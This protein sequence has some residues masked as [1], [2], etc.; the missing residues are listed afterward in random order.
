MNLKQTDWD[1]YYSKPYQTA[2]FTR[3]FTRRVLVDLMRKY[4]PMQSSLTIAEWGGGNSAFFE[5]IYAAIKPAEYH[6]LDNNQLGLDKFSERIGQRAGVAL[7]Q[8]DVLNPPCNLQADIVYSVG[9]IEHF[10]PQQ[11]ARAIQAHF[12]MVKPGGLVLITFPTPTFLYRAT[13]RVA[14]GLGQWIF[15]DERPLGFDEVLSSI[16][17]TGKVVHQ[18]I[19]WPLFLTQGVIAIQ[20]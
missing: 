11:T 2:A 18:Q 13:R 4:H 14:E 12:T 1:N 16:P 17:A 8:A 20:T 6:L 3:Q 5:N 9:L 19:L 7:H 15:H 10:N